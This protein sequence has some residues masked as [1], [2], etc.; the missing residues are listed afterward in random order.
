MPG[1]LDWAMHWPVCL[2]DLSSSV[3][4]VTWP[5]RRTSQ[6]IR[7]Q[8]V[9]RSTCLVGSDQYLRCVLTKWVVCQRTWLQL[10]FRWFWLSP[11]LIS[12]LSSGNAYFSFIL[13]FST[14]YHLFRKTVTFHTWIG[15]IVP[16]NR[17][18]LSLILWGFRRHIADIFGTTRM[19]R[20][21]FF[22]MLIKEAYL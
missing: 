1:W 4:W 3:C 11:T 13:I 2:L 17:T 7:W 12:F 15:K 16:I 21:P 9:V 6:W 22:G 19:L 20:A 10:F 8:R 5:T 14:F 18:C